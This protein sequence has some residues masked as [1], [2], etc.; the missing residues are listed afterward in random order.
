MIKE[1]KLTFI[2]DK[3]NKITLSEQLWRYKYCN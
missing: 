2:H 1:E 3:Q